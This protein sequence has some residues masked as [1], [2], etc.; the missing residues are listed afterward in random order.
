MDYIYLYGIIICLACISS[1]II[2]NLLRKIERIDEE[3]DDV[4]VNYMD[5]YNTLRSLKDTMY[6]IDSKQIFEKDDEVGVVFDGIKEA[7]EEANKLYGL[8]KDE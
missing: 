4:S 7:I 3:L 8:N 5:L 6:E 1:F 2:F